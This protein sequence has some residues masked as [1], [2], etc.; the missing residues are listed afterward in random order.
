MRKNGYKIILIKEGKYD[1]RQFNVSFHHIILSVGFI[2]ILTSSLFFLF[3]GKFSNWADI[4]TI[5]KHRRN[6]QILI[7][8]IEDNQNELIVL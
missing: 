3:S 6:N 7:Q 8:N 2:F 5:E 1:L 4:V